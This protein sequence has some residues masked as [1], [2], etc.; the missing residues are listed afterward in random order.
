MVTMLQNNPR[1]LTF[2][3]KVKFSIHAYTGL[4]ESYAMLLINNYHLIHQVSEFMNVLEPWWT[5]RNYGSSKCPI[6]CWWILK[7]GSWSFLKIPHDSWCEESHFDRVPRSLSSTTC[8]R[9]YWNIAKVMMG[10]LCVAGSR[11]KNEF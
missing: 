3:T 5:L 6:C 11:V 4:S 10:T 8:T 7:N 9:K 2:P 1:K